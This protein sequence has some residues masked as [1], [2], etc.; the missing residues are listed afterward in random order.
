MV[1]QPKRTKTQNTF[2]HPCTL[3]LANPVTNL[4]VNRINLGFICNCVM[5]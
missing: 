3:K 5:V 2:L 1:E 4:Y